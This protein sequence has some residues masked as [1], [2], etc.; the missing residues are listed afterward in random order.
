MKGKISQIDKIPITMKDGT[1]KDKFS[2]HF[3]D[4]PKAY[5]SWSCSF[6]VGDEAEGEVSEREW[7]DKTFYSIKFAGSQKTGGG[8]FQSRGKS[9]DEL[10][11]QVR[12]FAASYSKDVT[13][14][15]INQGTIKDSKAADASVLHYFNLF[16][17]ILEG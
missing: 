11:Q 14:A 9:P 3:E 6:K 15:F 4:D 10:K 16:K 7:N 2:I 1:I 8:G 5:E 12:S 13:V 17:G